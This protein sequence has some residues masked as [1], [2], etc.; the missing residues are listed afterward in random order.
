LNPNFGGLEDFRSFRNKVDEDEGSPLQ[1]GANLA[2]RP[3]GFPEPVS[4]EREKI[5]Q[6]AEALRVCQAR[7][8]FPL[9]KITPLS[10]PAG[11]CADKGH[12]MAENKKENSK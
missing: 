5:E 8:I 6:S 7:H 10:T 4:S 11:D 1:N 3:D 2:K 12:G 9:Q